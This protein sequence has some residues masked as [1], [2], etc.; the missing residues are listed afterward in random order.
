MAFIS[1]TIKAFYNL[2]IGGESG[3]EVPA[4][5]TDEE[6]T[7]RLRKLLADQGISLEKL[8]LDR[9]HCVLSGGLLVQVLTGMSWDDGDIDVFC[10][11]VE[12]P[13][14]RDRFLAE[15][16]RF[17]LVYATGCENDDEYRRLDKRMPTV[18]GFKDDDGHHFQIITVTNDTHLTDEIIAGFDFSICRNSY[19][20]VSWM[21][22]DQESLD[23]R[24]LRITDVGK[25]SVLATWSDKDGGGDLTLSDYD[26]FNN[27][28]LPRL[29]GVFAS[30][31]N[32]SFSHHNFVTIGRLRGEP[33]YVTNSGALSY[34]SNLMHR[35]HKYHDRG[36][37]L[38]YD[39]EKEDEDDDDDW[40]CVIQLALEFRMPGHADLQFNTWYETFKT[41][42]YLNG[43]DD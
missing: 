39:P 13:E 12:F 33:P 11:E 40:H 27:Q 19:D 32:E 30:H 26:N 34:V 38:K 8:L 10:H 20:G 14:V 3:G 4:P 31:A 17:K 25:R 16:P 42:G 6:R 41:C 15:H 35:I 18:Y 23:A 7:A 24:E 9:K 21:I 36:F 1:S 43:N 37:T 28:Y 5:T 2:I 29:R 22:G